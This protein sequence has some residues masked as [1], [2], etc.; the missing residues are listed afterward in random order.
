MTD[1]LARTWEHQ[2]GARLSLQR[3]AIDTGFATQSVYRLGARPGPRHRHPVRG[4]GA[5]DR[6]V[7]VSGPTKIEVMTNGQRFKRGLNLW[8]VS[9]SFFKKELYK[10]LGLPKPTTEQ[11]AAGFTFPTGYIHLPDIV[12]DEWIKQLVAE[13]QVI[14][15]SRRG[16][17]TR[18]EWRQTAPGT[19]LWIVGSMPGLPSGWRVPTGG[20]RPAGGAWKVSSGWM[21]PQSLDPRSLRN[22]P[23]TTLPPQPSRQK[24]T[25]PRSRSRQSEL[26][27]D[28]K[29]RGNPRPLARRR[30]VYYRG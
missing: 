13:Q 24:V 19:R 30:V 11:L 21:L 8:T 2:T 16:F 15:R 17:A 28:I 27:G 6:L 4:V 23:R 18:T 25:R 7:P 9:V 14:I 20:A 3:L 22:L 5:Y 10:H 12:S 1:L 26:A 29:R